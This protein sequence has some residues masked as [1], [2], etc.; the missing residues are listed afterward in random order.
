MTYYVFKAVRGQRWPKNW[1]LVSEHLNIE[2]AEAAAKRLC[3]P[4][5]RTEP[6]RGLDKA[7]F[8]PADTDY[9]S[10]MIHTQKELT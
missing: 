10:A 5:M 7:F 1:K 4:N 9:W 6:G 3:P 8:G 2:A